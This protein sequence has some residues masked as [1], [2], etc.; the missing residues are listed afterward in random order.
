MTLASVCSFD[1]AAL[2]ERL[3][4]ASNPLDR[5]G[6]IEQLASYYV[7]A[8]VQRSRQLLNEQERI[9]LRHPQEDYLSRFYIHRAILENQAYQYGLADLYFQKAIR[10]IEDNG[11]AGSRQKPTSI[12]PV[13]AS[14][15]NGWTKPAP[16]WKKR[17]G[18][19]GSIPTP[20]WKPGSSAGRDSSNCITPIFPEP[21]N[22]CWKPTDRSWRSGMNP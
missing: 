14:I 15:I 1:V 20:S 10:L 17:A 6:L 12:I 7:F 8:N 9:L 22:C 2:E 16:T 18:C 19:S 11:D 13:P 21:L 3:E 5:L 4:H